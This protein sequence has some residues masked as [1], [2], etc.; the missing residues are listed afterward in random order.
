MKPAR[1]CV[2]PALAAS[3]LLL[4][5]LPDHGLA[6]AHESVPLNRRRPVLEPGGEPNVVGVTRDSLP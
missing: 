3:L 2:L 1:Q 5:F 4:L 6:S